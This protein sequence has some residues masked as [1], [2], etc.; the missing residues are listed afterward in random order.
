MITYR[1]VDTL[2]AQHRTTPW[3]VAARMHCGT[4]GAKSRWTFGLTKAK[5]LR[6][7]ADGWLHAHVHTTRAGCVEII[8]EP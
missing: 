2:Q 8:E 6:N 3:F 4:C 7:I 5:A 1:M